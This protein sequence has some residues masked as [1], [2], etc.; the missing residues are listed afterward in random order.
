MHRAHV[1]ISGK[2]QGVWFRDHTNKKAQQTGVA[3]WVQNL[4]DGRVE[5]VF[6]GPRDAVAEMIDWCHQGSPSAQ[7]DDVAVVWENPGHLTRFEIR[8]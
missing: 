8:Y 6:E 3:G 4:P 2:V 1:W 7:V 5:A